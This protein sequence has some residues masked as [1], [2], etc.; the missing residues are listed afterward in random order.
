MFKIFYLTV[1]LFLGAWLIWRGVLLQSSDLLGVPKELACT[2]PGVRYLSPL[3]NLD[4]GPGN[5][6]ITNVPAGVLSPAEEALLQEDKWVEGLVEQ[7]TLFERLLISSAYHLTMASE[8]ESLERKGWEEYAAK[9]T[10]FGLNLRDSGKFLNSFASTGHRLLGFLKTQVLPLKDE[11]DNVYGEGWSILS[12]DPAGQVEVVAT[13][14]HHLRQLSD[15]IISMLND[16]E[17]CIQALN[18]LTRTERQVIDHITAQLKVDVKKTPGNL[19][20]YLN[21]GLPG[22]APINAQVERIAFL[23]GLYESA[24]TDVEWLMREL[25]S[26]PRVL[27]LVRW[28][29]VA[30]IRGGRKPSGNTVGGDQDEVVAVEVE[31]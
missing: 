14:A 22:A 4:C 9:S 26:Y 18:N 21:P 6:L 1:F 24:L 29:V 10:D 28:Q 12:Q 27:R 13:Y 25:R 8:L 30:D 15:L 17:A 16:G 11:V 19:M 20:Y 7:E 31:E 23:R 3:L 5:F 2:I